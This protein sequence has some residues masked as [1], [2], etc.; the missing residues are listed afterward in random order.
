MKRGVGVVRDL[1]ATTGGGESC[2]KELLFQMFPVRRRSFPVRVCC[3]R[4]SI[5]YYCLRVL[6]LRVFVFIKRDQA[7]A[8]GMGV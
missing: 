2:L 4:K 8:K 3:P 5:T 7:R 1:R 6:L